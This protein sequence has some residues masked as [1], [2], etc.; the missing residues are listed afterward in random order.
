MV[1][2]LHFLHV[3]ILQTLIVF[4][5]IAIFSLFVRRYSRKHT[6]ING[7]NGKDQRIVGARGM[8]KT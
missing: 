8:E 1:N 4:F 3:Q 7:A 6:K 5:Y 2:V